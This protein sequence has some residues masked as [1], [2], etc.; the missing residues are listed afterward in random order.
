MKQ[1]SLQIFTLLI[2]IFCYSQNNEQKIEY[3]LKSNGTI[4]A[5]KSIFEMRI[6]PLK[7]GANKT[8]ST[9]SK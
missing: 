1:L 8:D 9:N 5:Y 3:I 4:E 7:Y 6:E 2:S